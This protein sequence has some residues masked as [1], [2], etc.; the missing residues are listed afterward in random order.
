MNPDKPSKHIPALAAFLLAGITL[1]VFAPVVRNE[2]TWWDDQQTIHHNPDFNPTSGKAI[3]KYWKEPAQGLYAPVTFTLWG[4]L[5]YVAETKRAQP[6]GVHLDPRI[7]H[8]ANLVLHVAGVLVLFAILRTLSARVWPA[9]AGALLFALHPVQVESVA[10]ASGL[11]DV[12]SGLL[13]LCAIHQYLIFTHETTTRKRWT[14]FTSGA[15]MLILA[16]L[17]KPSAMV[18]PVVVAVLDLWIV[19]RPWKQVA[20]SAGIWTV[21]VMPFA[22][23]ARS[24]QTTGL[25]TH[26]PWWQRPLVA[27]DAIAFYLYKLV[28]PITLAP[29]YARRPAVVVAMW[30]GAWAFVVCLIPL[31]LGFFLWRSRQT[32]PW[33]F[34]GALIFLAVIFPMLGFSP[35]QFQYMSTVSDHYLYLALLGPALALTWAL[36]RFRD[37]AVPAL[38]AIAMIGFA[39]R[40]ATQLARWRDDVSLW[41]HTLAASPNSFVAP[42]NLAAGLGRQSALI[43]LAAVDARDEGNTE[44]AQK[45]HARRLEL[46]RQAVVL[47]EQSCA[48]FPDY[49]PAQHNAFVQYMRLNDDR[50]AVRHL[51]EMLRISATGPE[52]LQHKLATYHD[53]AGLLWMRL[54]EYKK[55]ADHFAQLARLDPSHATARK[56]FEEAQRRLAGLDRD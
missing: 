29:D 41:R 5:A 10:W 25:L 49:L 54:G 16:M 50:N 53:T 44:L 32:R 19:R 43:Q 35:F 33:L 28:W 24:V 1:A 9:F 36:V 45:L 31:A 6:D 52:F 18:V 15:I 56:N 13:S 12:L 2:F 23:L 55:A 37:K 34:A 26:V 7:Y 20:L 4:G 38:C 39:V 51:E 21:L 30:G 3:L 48:I 14:Y 27:G 40:S 47:L 42:N 46:L 11:K 8:L 17:S 22:L